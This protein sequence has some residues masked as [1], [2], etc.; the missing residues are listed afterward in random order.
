MLSKK[1]E[2]FLEN[3]RLYLLTTGK[4]EQE[5]NELIEEL[6][7]HLMESEKQGKNITEII[8]G[9][10]EDYMD[11]LREE[12]ATDYMKMM[13]LIPIFMIGVTAYLIM[14]PAIRGEFA[15]NMFQ[16]IGFPIVTAICF[17]ITIVFLQQAG[18]RQFSN[19][20]FYIIGMIASSSTIFLFILLMLGS[21]F[22]VSPFYVA[23]DLGNGIVVGLCTLIFIGTA[24]WSKAWFPIW[25][26]AILFIPDLL[27]RF[28]QVSM[29]TVFIVQLGSFILIFLLLL[30]QALLVERKRTQKQS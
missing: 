10:P 16:V 7:I 19:K 13:K 25:I 20:K 22:L 12:M 6:Q 11:S 8:E 17:I 5:V 29:E 28:S 21:K 9:S 27:I 2:S 26:P 4:K 15:L 1:S 23:D 14:G 3:L 24:V 30:L 18:R